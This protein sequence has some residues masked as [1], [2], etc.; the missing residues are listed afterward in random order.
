MA[1]PVTRLEV[2]RAIRQSD[3]EA[4]SSLVKGVE[5]SSI[6]TGKLPLLASCTNVSIAELLIARGADIEAKN[7]VGRTPLFN[8]VHRIAAAKTLVALG[9]DVNASCHDGQTVLS[10]AAQNKKL[11]VLYLLIDNGATAWSE[12]SKSNEVFAD[13]FENFLK[14]SRKLGH[15]RCST[16]DEVLLA[17]THE[18]TYA[19]ELILSLM[20]I[21]AT[22]TMELLLKAATPL[23]LKVLNV[24]ALVCRSEGLVGTNVDWNIS[25]GMRY[26]RE[27]HTGLRFDLDQELSVDDVDIILPAMNSTLKK[28]IKVKGTVGNVFRHISRT[29]KME[30]NDYP[31]LY[32][33]GLYEEV[34][35]G[36]TYYSL[37]IEASTDFKTDI[38]IRYEGKI[39]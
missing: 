25:N 30:R 28:V 7:A 3:Y 10:W 23:L 16:A 5:L 35:K 34:H 17:P 33:K 12:C 8:C 38:Y 21:R 6:D 32:F 9:A 19:V 22:T 15:S 4:L 27:K 18:D 29:Y 26:A 20:E 14:V 1:R 11:D 39:R 13:I 2:L 36:K 24:P 31:C 37:D